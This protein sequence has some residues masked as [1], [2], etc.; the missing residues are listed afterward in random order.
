MSPIENLADRLARVQDVFDA[1][2]KEGASLFDPPPDDDYQTLVHEFDFFEGGTPKQAYMKIRFVVVHHAEQAGRFCEK[3]YGLEDPDAIG[4]LKADL[5][6]LGEDV[7]NFNVA[8]EVSSGRLQERLLDTPVL[9]RVKRNPNRIDPKTRKARVN[10]YIQQKL[11]E[12]DRSARPVLAT[13]APP[14]GQ[15]FLTSSTEHPSD[16]PGAKAD[17]F[18]HPQQASLD[19]VP[20]DGKEQPAPGQGNQEAHLRE[21]GCICEEPV[22]VELKQAVGHVDCPLPGHAPF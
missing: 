5:H 14:P 15:Q 21:R 2:P 4:Y 19:D 9:V 18:V 13:T 7:D 8:E 17:E 20:F 6:R 11:G 22:K 1:A 10:T 12:P 3:V 16:V